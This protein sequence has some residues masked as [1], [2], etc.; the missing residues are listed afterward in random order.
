MT[1]NAISFINPIPK[2]YKNLPPSIEDM[3]D[4]LAFIY[5]GPCQ[6][7]KVDFE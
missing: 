5:T 4:V 7:T 6:P 3:N 2:V 1:A